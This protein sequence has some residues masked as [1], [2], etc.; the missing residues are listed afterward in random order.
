MQIM[1]LRQYDFA[2][3]T[4]I[5]ISL[6]ICLC[7]IVKVTLEEVNS[8]DFNHFLWQVIA[9]IRNSNAEELQSI[10]AFTVHFASL[11]P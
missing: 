7:H 11:L 10:V 9:A 1:N 2:K 3:C 6:F 4:S 5:K 8:C